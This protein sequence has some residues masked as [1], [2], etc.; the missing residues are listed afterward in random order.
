MASTSSSILRIGCSTTELPRPLII[1]DLFPS[2]TNPTKTA[3]KLPSKLPS[4]AFHFNGVLRIF[5]RFFLREQFG[6]ALPGIV[7]H[8]LLKRSLLSRSSHENRLRARSRKEAR[9]DF[10]PAPFHSQVIDH[11]NFGVEPNVQQPVPP[12]EANR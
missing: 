2:L 4:F 5:R 7:D 12:E 6:D 10:S 11:T 1:N 3:I 8:P 9:N